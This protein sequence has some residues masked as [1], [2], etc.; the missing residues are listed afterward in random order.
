MSGPPGGLGY[1]I[2]ASALDRARQVFDAQGQE[3]TAQHAQFR[4]EA[5][6]PDSAFGNLPQSYD[7]ANKYQAF[8]KQIQDDLQRLQESLTGCGDRLGACAENYRAAEAANVFPGQ[9]GHP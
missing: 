4:G 3:V 6:L 9:P 2:T 5:A 7:Y 1:Q 8:Y